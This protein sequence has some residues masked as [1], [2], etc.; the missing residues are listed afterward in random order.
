MVQGG[1]RRAAGFDPV[2]GVRI[3]PRRREAEVCLLLPGGRPP[4]Q[5]VRKLVELVNVLVHIPAS[6][7]QPFIWRTRALTVP[8]G[9]EVSKERLR[10]IFPST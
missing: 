4:H 8:Y 10:A 5:V 3:G 1:E 7:H 2:R 9:G 6:G